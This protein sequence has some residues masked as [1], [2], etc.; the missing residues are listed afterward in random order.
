MVKLKLNSPFAIC[1]GV[2]CA[3]DGSGIVGTLLNSMVSK[4]LLRLIDR[5]TE[6]IE[7]IPLRV[8]Q[9]IFEFYLAC[10][11]VCKLTHDHIPL[12]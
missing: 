8:R 3:D 5:G 9:M 1:L 4:V 2:G 11:D 7:K 10:F 6:N 12:F